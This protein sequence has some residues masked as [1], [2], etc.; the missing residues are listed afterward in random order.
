MTARA[1]KAG[2]KSKSA[3][4]I[5]K[6]S[7][8][9]AASAKPTSNPLL[10]PW[11]TPFGI[12]PFDK[13]EARHFVPALQRAFAEH[14]AE[15]RTIASNPARPTFANTILALE[16]SG[17]LLDR[18]GH[19]FSNLEAA[20][21][22]DALAEIAR[23]MSPRFADHESAI[24][25]DRKLFKRI[26]DLYQRRETLKLD[27]EALRLVERTHLAFVR[28]G[29]A[30]GAAE[31]K[32]VAAINQR[33]ASLVTQFMQNVL[34]DEQSW[35]M[36]LDG[37]ADLAGLP[38]GFRASAAREAQERGLA[39]RHVIT[40][41]RSS[42][43]GFLTF[44]ARRDLREQ[45]FNAWIR[46]GANGGA[47]DNRGILLEIVA[48][49]QEYAALL[50]YETYSAFA[51][52]DTMAK[53]PDAVDGLL[54]EVWKHAVGKAGEERDALA[55]AAKAEGSNAPIAAWDWRYYAEKVRKARF[56]LDEAALRPYLQLD[57]VIAAA[58]DCAS[59][60]FGLKFKP[61]ADVPR[62][63]ADVRAWEVTNRRGE[64]VGL[65]LG[66]YFARSSKRSGA[67]MSS[68]RGQHKIGKGSRPIIIN[69]MNFAK[70]AEGEPTLLS[71]DDARTLFHEF[72]HGLHG[73]LSDVTYPSLWG[74]S[75][76]RDF[77]E[78]PS[79]LYEHWLSRAE[80]L[81][82]FALHYKTGKPI[83]AKLLS[84]LK[85]ARNFNQGFA[86]VEFTASALAD[87]QLYSKADVPGDLDRFEAEVL[88]QI[89]MPSEIV[90]RHRLPHFM[91][92][93]GGYASAYY[94]YM[95]SEVMDADAF[96]AFEEAGDIFDRKT[97]DRLKRFIYS[98][99]NMRDPEEAY[100]AF[101]GRAPE[102]DGLLRN[103]GFASAK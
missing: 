96:A 60:L 93:V 3:Q 89:G 78:L 39:G 56:D 21:S 84:R 101:R 18:I 30:L 70:G 19:V 45:A 15:V 8:K 28:A 99:G 37:E 38:D 62:Y 59:R 48:L 52:A 29:A 90:M 9:K 24:L 51:L 67:W 20:D 49:R 103:R 1:S 61:A 6:G 88:G 86:T 23:Q 72:G 10:K 64:H 46:R 73:L 54:G 42:V 2:G 66:D 31:K 44:S 33:L 50:G 47:T 91:H 79:Q 57:N 65:F 4:R 102:I 34:K 16:K 53:T 76:S 43:E 100:I 71:F 27:A 58:F 35:H 87:M 14:R 25:L 80:V 26:D 11:R 5:R 36:V 81:E 74:T 63:H 77:V 95:W 92:I 55:A 13:I 83:P 40:L 7:Q 32:R 85:A 68:F 17:V 69:V 98:A 82:R 41:A 75:V 94:S 22:T 97:A 12:A